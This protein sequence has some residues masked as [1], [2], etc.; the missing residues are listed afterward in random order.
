MEHGAGGI[1]D[2]GVSQAHCMMTRQ[3]LTWSW[4]PLL[5]FLMM[6]VLLSGW[7]R[8]GLTISVQ[9]REG[10]S[11]S[12]MMESVGTEKGK[13]AVCLL[14]RVSMSIICQHGFNLER[15]RHHR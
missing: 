4:V 14:H 11:M 9:V 7:P 8:S 10:G 2:S 5:A 6:A 1:A 13:M 15:V 3:L 12:R